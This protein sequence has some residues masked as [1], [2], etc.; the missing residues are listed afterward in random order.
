MASSQGHYGLREAPSLWSEERTEALTDPLILV[1]HCPPAVFTESLTIYLLITWVLHLERHPQEVVAM[2]GIYVDDFLTAG[3]SPV[4]RS[5]LATL[6]K[7]HV[8][9]V[10]STV[11]DDGC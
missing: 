5:F 10:G 6:R 11:S 9:N 8:E 4:V 2:S 7:M 1:S 3:P